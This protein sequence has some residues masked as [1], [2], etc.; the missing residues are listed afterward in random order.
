MLLIG[1]SA[2]KLKREHYEGK[3]VEITKIKAHRKYLPSPES[4]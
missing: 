3:T 2:N 1:L 4:S